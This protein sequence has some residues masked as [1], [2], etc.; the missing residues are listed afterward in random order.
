MTMLNSKYCL[1]CCQRGV[2]RMIYIG[3]WTSTLTLGLEAWL[4]GLLTAG[5]RQCQRLDIQLFPQRNIVAK[6]PE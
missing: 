1:S 6:I 5:V 2:F 3:G 4:A